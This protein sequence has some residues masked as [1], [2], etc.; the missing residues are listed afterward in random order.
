MSVSAPVG[1]AVRNLLVP[2]QGT[3]HAVEFTGGFTGTPFPIDWRQ[4]AID[5]SPFQPQGVHIDNTSGTAPLSITF[6]PTGW[7]VTAKAGQ[8]RSANFPS[9]NGGTCQIVGDPSAQNTKVVFVDYPVF[10]DT[11]GP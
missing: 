11:W 1:M 9:V 6:M 8:Q 3:P 4:Y 5:N 2:S 7:T 10:P